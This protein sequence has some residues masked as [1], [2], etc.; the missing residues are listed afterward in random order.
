[1]FVEN[2]IVASIYTCKYGSTIKI[3]SCLESI[4]ATNIISI[5]IST[6]FQD[7]IFLPGMLIDIR[8]ASLKATSGVVL[9]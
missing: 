6:T 2:I 7:D 5:D 4:F 9:G 8:I 3:C 1:M